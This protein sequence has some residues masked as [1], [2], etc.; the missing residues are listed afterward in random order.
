METETDDER[1]DSL[2]E[3]Y[4]FLGSEWNELYRIRKFRQSLQ[5]ITKQMRDSG[6]KGSSK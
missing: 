4:S 5:A 6:F 1:V 3:K 2:L